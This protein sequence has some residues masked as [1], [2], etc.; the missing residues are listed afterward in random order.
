MFACVY[1]PN[2]ESA[3]SLVEC[4]YAFSPLVEETAEN[5]VVLDIEGC[6]LLF[7]SP[8]DV[9]KEIARHAAKLDLKVNVAVA[10]NPDAAIHAARCFAGVTVIAPGKESKHL[11]DLPL[12]A[13]DGTL[14]RV[15]ADRAAKILETLELWGIRCF[16]ELAALPEAGVSERLGPEG[17]RLQKLAR[18]E[19]DRPLLLAKPAPA[20]EKSIE[21]DDPIELLEPLSFILARLLNQLCANL[22]AHGLAVDSF[23]LRLKLEDKT[24]HERSIRL[25]FPMRD[26]RIFLKLLLLDIE[27]HP[28][29]LAIVAVSITCEPAKPRSIQNGLFQPLAPEPEKLELTLA[30]LTRLVGESNVGSPELVD[31]HRPGAFRIKR[32]IVKRGI[33]RRGRRGRG[34]REKAK[35]RG[36]E[37]EKGG[38][39]LAPSAPLP[40][41]PSASRPL[42][43]S[44]PLP[45]SPSLLG[46]RVFRPPLRAVVEAASGW[47]TRIRAQMGAGRSIRGKVL[48]LAG[49]WRTSGDWW[50]E[51]GWARD[52]WDVTVASS[53]ASHEQQTVYR[54]FRDLRS[55]GWFVEGIYD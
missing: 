39:A 33:N 36:G 44:P 5:T 29:R 46:F 26:S 32:F 23:Q 4:A 14:A 24:E 20:F 55:D 53:E 17:V 28:P 8:R 18:G 15:E 41:C 22:Q 38:V 50:A 11:G 48:R 16:R 42:S 9:A 47:P 54:I 34:A 37:G 51:D 49:P 30:R 7:G 43:P 21:L 10:H 12:A 40:L 31:T 2:L 45:V 1:S 27:S 35:G 19:N 6:E 3:R 13:L 25:P 52:E